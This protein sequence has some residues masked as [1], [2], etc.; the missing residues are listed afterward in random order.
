VRRITLYRPNIKLRGVR[1]QL[2]SL[3]Q[4]ANRIP[5]ESVYRPGEKYINFKVPLPGFLVEGPR[6][7]HRIQAEVI[8]QLLRAASKLARQ[9]PPEHCS[10]YR[11]AVLLT[12]P[13]L[14][15]S[16]VTLFYDEEYFN[17]F[18]YEN[19]LPD[20]QRPS[21]LYSLEMPPEFDIECGCHVS[22]DD[23]NFQYRSNHWTITSSTPH[24]QVS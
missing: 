8:T 13:D 21:Q 12:V 9:Q 15:G 3:K 16:E 20:A 7:R 19:S 4:W 23:D 1:R 2:R 18:V 6:T 14:F 10:F 17:G 5:S 11:V 22:Y 24:A